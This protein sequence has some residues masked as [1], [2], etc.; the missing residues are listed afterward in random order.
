MPAHSPA[1][2]GESQGPCRPIP[3]SGFVSTGVDGFDARIALSMVE[4]CRNHV[5]E[6]TMAEAAVTRFANR[7]KPDDRL[8]IENGSLAVGPVQPGW[9]SAQWVVEPVEPGST[10]LYFRFKNLWQPDRFLHTES[11]APE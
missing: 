7:C 8:H 3:T 4:Q 2:R 6:T 1:R 11:G 5:R 9:L 10:S